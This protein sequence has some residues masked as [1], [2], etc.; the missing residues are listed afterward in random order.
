MSARHSLHPW[1]GPRRPPQ[2]RPACARTKGQAWDPVAKPL[3]NAGLV[4]RS[5][6][7]IAGDMQWSK[8]G[9]GGD[10]S[11][12]RR[13][14]GL[15]PGGTPGLAPACRP[16]C[17][18]VARPSRWFIQRG[19]HTVHTALTCG[20]PPMVDVLAVWIWR[21]DRAGICG[22]GGDVD[23]LSTEAIRDPTQLP[24]I[25]TTR[26]RHHAVP[27]NATDHR[28]Q[29]PPKPIR[30]LPAHP[31]SDASPRRA[32]RRRRPGPAAPEAPTIPRRSAQPSGTG[33]RGSRRR[34]R[35]LTSAVDAPD[36]ARTRANHRCS[37]RRSSHAT[38]LGN[39]R[40]SCTPSR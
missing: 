3:G 19:E 16:M 13:T 23:A 12:H 7:C 4:H 9:S 22:I 31:P 30:H 15:A 39:S 35:T 17:S 21:H 14:P 1:T 25:A 27:A 34:S 18:S 28:R 32:E 33:R 6:R 2:R 40:R 37:R 8:P 20:E 38:P 24:E 36:R 26:H 10:S 29:R 5:S 11:R